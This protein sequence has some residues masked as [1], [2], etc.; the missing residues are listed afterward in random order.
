MPRTLDPSRP[1][2]PAPSLFHPAASI[3]R[4]GLLLLASGALLASR[5]IP[6]PPARAQEPPAAENPGNASPAPA[7]APGNTATVIPAA[8]GNPPESATRIL[9]SR[10]HGLLVVELEAAE[11]ASKASPMNATAIPTKPETPVSIRFN[12][13][14]GDTMAAALNEVQKCLAVRH[15]RWPSGFD[16][17]IA[18]EDRY[19]GKDGPSAAV[20]CALLVD[21]LISGRPL[22]PR[23]A[24]TGDMNADGA[25]QPVGG[26]AAKIRGAAARDCDLVG[27][28]YRNAS[29]VSDLLIL[30]GPGPLYETQ[31]FALKSI[32]EAIDIA[33]AAR[34]PD[35]QKAIGAFAEI[36]DVLARNSRQA[37]QVLRHPA[38]QAKLRAIVSVAPNHLSAHLLMLYGQD[39][40]PKTLSLAGSLG[41]LERTAAVL[42]DAA[43]SGRF[44]SDSNLE[45]DRIG[46]AVSEMRSIRRSL[47]HRIWP[48]ADALEGFGTLLRKLVNSP[49]SSAAAK[50]KLA[51]EIV[52]AARRIDHEVQ[53]LRRNREIVE[54][55][56]D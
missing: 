44:T 18:F 52:A 37:Y 53:Q 43:R 10:I 5:T 42:I 36:R 12:Q 30:D 19:S 11:F 7:P 45:P 6:T 22:D 21:A 4:K 24:V 1:G 23:V 2:E 26:V 41:Y 8:T 39:R 31:I 17:E 34:R 55:L 33:A 46:D 29:T 56:M 47:D 14:V 38:T 32:D 20:A 16:V 13:P 54:E 51:E 27:I 3:R 28:P 35:L 50:N 48:Y 40:A 15:G 25:V 9:Q 49:P